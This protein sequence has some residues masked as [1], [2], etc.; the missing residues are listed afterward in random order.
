MRLTFET[1]HEDVLHNL[2]LVILS[3]HHEH[4][5]LLDYDVEGALDALIAG[6]TAEARG[7][8]AQARQLPGLRQPLME[9][10]R[11]TCEGLLGRG[12]PKAVLIPASATVDEVAACLGRVRKSVRMWTREAGRKGYLSFIERYVD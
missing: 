6:Y 3:F 7:R 9:A 8:T 10:L 12:S 5:E 1:Q 4:P 2:E 11:A